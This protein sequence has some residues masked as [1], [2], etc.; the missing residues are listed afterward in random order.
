MVLCTGPPLFFFDLR[1]W[2]LTSVPQPRIGA[3]GI[4]RLRSPPNH[5]KRKRSKQHRRKRSKAV[6]PRVSSPVAVTESWL[7]VHRICRLAEGAGWPPREAF[8]CAMHLQLHGVSPTEVERA[9]QDAERRL[10]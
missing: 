3:G 1:G 6:A 7:A 8:E 5:M 9:F 10:Q 4:R 2:S